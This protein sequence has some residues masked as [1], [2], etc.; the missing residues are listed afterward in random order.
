MTDVSEARSATEFERTLAELAQ[1]DRG[2]LRPTLGGA[3]DRLVSSAWEAYGAIDGVEG[4]GLAL[5][6]RLRAAA[7]DARDAAA[8]LLT[9]AA[10]LDGGA[11]ALLDLESGSTAVSPLE[12]AGNFYR[13][14]LTHGLLAAR[15]RGTCE[16]DGGKE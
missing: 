11:A 10:L 3:I 5:P 15:R 4:T 6:P 2:P 13:I 12:Q 14:E 16:K 9:A 7:V 1:S 8:A